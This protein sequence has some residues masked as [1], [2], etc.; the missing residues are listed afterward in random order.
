MILQKG[1]IGSLKTLRIFF[2]PNQIQSA[3]A[4][5]PLLADYTYSSAYNPVVIKYF[6][7]SVCQLLYQ[8]DNSD[9]MPL[10]VL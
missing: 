4:N 9:P 6:H 10:L 5:L 8:S 3:L 2:F 7:F 1:L